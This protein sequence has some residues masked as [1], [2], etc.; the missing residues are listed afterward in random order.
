MSERILFCK[1]I[2]RWY[3]H[4]PVGKD[5]KQQKQQTHPHPKS[6]M[7]TREYNECVKMYGDDLYRFALRYTGNGVTSEDAVQDVFVILWEKR[8]SIVASGAKGYL[9]RMLYRRLIDSH[10]HQMVEHDAREQMTPRQEEYEQH[11]GFELRDAM[12]QALNQLPDVQ[13]QLVLMKDLEG[14]GYEEMAELT[15]LSEQQVGV[16]LFRARKTMKKLLEDYRYD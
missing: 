10:R 13:R 14:Y 7:T 12:Q 5:T 6:T 11:T 8:E 4:V 9:M 1:P 15:G 16:Y 2:K 3:A